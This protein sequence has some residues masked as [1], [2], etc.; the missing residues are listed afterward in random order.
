MYTKIYFKEVA[1][2][3]VETGKSEIRRTGQQAGNSSRSQCRVCSLEAEFLPLLGLWCF[4]LRP[5]TDWMST[6]HIMKG[7][8]YSKSTDLNVNHI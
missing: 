4:H 5:S 6:I 3:T 8:L 1:H 2:T 7:E